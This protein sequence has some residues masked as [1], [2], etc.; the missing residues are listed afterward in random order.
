MASTEPVRLRE[1]AEGRLPAW[2][3]AAESRRVHMARVAA[4]MGEWAEALGLGEEDR[5]RWRAAGWLHDALRDA[6]PEEL[7]AELPEGDRLLPDP[8]LHGPAA[9]H[10]LRGQLDAELLEAIRH[11][12]TGHPELGALGRAL[13]LAD[14]L[15]PGRT[16]EEEWRA[17][18]RTRMPHAMDQVLE[19]VVAA[20]LTHL[21]ESRKLLREESVEFWNRLLLERDR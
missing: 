20:R 7:R 11:H 12:T 1:A 14:F 15:E 16:F 9:A 8:L 13:H 4:L 17:G 2:T 21:L 18:L 19:E 5:L 6:P 3:R 10:R